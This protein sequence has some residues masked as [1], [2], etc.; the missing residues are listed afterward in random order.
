MTDSTER[1]VKQKT[2]DA[3]EQLRMKQKMISLIDL[4]TLDKE[5]DTEEKVAQ[6]VENGSAKNALGTEVAAVCVYPEFVQAAKRKIAKLEKDAKGMRVATVVN[7]PSGDA[8]TSEAVAET[9]AALQVGADEI[10]L[11]ICFKDYL[12]NAESPKS[13]EMVRQVKAAIEQN[14]KGN[15]LLKVILETG[16]LKCEHLI[17]KASLD[18][19]DNGADF[20]KTSTGKTPTGATLAAAQTMLEAIKA[21]N[22]QSGLKIS[23]GVR[24]HED[25][26]GYLQLVETVLGPKAKEFLRPESFRFGVSGL[27]TNLLQETEVNTSY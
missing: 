20:I 12:S 6:L 3:S 14:K 17:K 15:C 8:Q 2:A 9:R 24:T 19:L 21:R 22:H 23:G 5:K 27:L 7:F 10:D 25:A 13:C 4:T 18:A 26:L 11:V 1:R 16:E